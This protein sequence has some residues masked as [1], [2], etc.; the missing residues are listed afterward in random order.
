VEITGDRYAEWCN[1]VAEKYCDINNQP[2]SEFDYVAKLGKHIL[3]NPSRSQYD[4]RDR[5]PIAE[6][7]PHD[8]EHF[9]EQAIEQ[10]I[11]LIGM[12]SNPQITPEKVP[13]ALVLVLPVSPLQA[14][15]KTLWG[16][17]AKDAS[18]FWQSFES[19]LLKHCSMIHLH[20]DPQEVAVIY[21]KFTNTLN[22]H[23]VR[24]SGPLAVCFLSGK[25]NHTITLLPI[26]EYD[27]FDQDDSMVF[28]QGCMDSA[29][30][31]GGLTLTCSPGFL[32]IL[33]QKLL[34]PQ[35][36]TEVV[37]NNFQGMVTIRFCV[38]QVLEGTK[39]QM[40]ERWNRQDIMEVHAEVHQLD[41]KASLQRMKDVVHAPNP[42]KCIAI[43][44]HLRGPTPQRILDFPGGSGN[45]LESMTWSSKRLHVW[46]GTSGEWWSVRRCIRGG[47]SVLICTRMMFGCRFLSTPTSGGRSTL[48]KAGGR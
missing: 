40:M 38:D 23:N 1:R 12:M 27:E 4:Q 8:K 43:E 37:S 21:D 33:K 6:K 17:E 42:K 31:K 32:A 26:K 46:G 5:P 20:H 10:A 3:M 15:T 24:H 25:L 36:H 44:L 16:K 45:T 11:A 39:K 35:A 13:S 28:D 29:L 7:R 22:T 2:E 48:Q 14:I 47:W 41:E 19:H 34:I 9:A 18:P 30:S